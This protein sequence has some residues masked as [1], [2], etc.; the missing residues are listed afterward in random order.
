MPPYH[1]VEGLLEAKETDASGRCYICVGSAW[2][3]VDRP[4]SNTLV[5]GESLRVRYTRGKRAINIDR[6][7][8]ARGPG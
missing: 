5:V 3:E 8:P 1:K 7:L 2:V 6:I 4:T